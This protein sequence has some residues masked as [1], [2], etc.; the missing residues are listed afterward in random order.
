MFDMSVMKL[1]VLVLAPSAGLAASW[2]AL[3]AKSAGSKLSAI[4]ENVEFCAKHAKKFINKPMTKG[5]AIEYA[6]DHCALDKKVDDKNFVCPHYKEVLVNAF[7]RESTQRELN[8]ETFCEVAEAY[9]YALQMGAH[10]IPNMGVGEGTNFTVT[11]ECESIVLKSLKPQSALPSKNAPDFW[12]ALCMNQD[13]AHFLPSRTRWCK[14]SHMPTHSAS[15]CEAIRT[16]ARDEVTIFGSQEL[17]SKEVCEM[18]DEFVED[19]HINVEAYLHVVH[20]KEQHPVPE[21]DDR[22]RALQSAQMKN[23]AGK[24][25]IRDSAGEPVRSA[26]VGTGLIFSMVSI[27]SAL[28]CLV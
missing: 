1:L 13:C 5:R 9:I 3:L 12:Y 24:H 6:V 2:S 27:L 21:P 26:A 18:Y 19:T 28:T 23:E 11:E 4:S 22:A 17:S 25:K 16:Y 14:Q 8:P 10:N 15:V 7:A 20:G